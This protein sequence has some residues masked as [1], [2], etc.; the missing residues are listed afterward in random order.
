MG[1][2]I[3]SE[4]KDIIILKVVSFNEQVRTLTLES[5]EEKKLS[6]ITHKFKKIRA[7]IP[8]QTNQYLGLESRINDLTS[9]TIDVL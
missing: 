6:A 5:A 2:A 1:C 8:H 4:L 3:N 9:I 7:V